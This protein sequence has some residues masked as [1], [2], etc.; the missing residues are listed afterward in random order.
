MNKLDNFGPVY[1]INLKDHKHRLKNA[2][3]EFA[4]YNVSNYTI[5]DAVDGRNNDL[6]N[7]VSG[8][9]PN[10]KPSEIGCIASHIKALNHWLNT[11]DSEYAIIMEDD[12]SF[13]T[14]KYWQWDWNYVV[15][16]IPKSAEIIQLI[17]IQNEPIKFNLHKKE[18]YNH[19]NKSHYY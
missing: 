19:K 13:D 12:F 17:M 18:Q 10:L 5:I 15:K 7:I 2:E 3:Q 6:S 9:Y 16:N 8:K 11:S 4:K 1:L 14:V